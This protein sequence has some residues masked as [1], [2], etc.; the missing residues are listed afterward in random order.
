MVKTRKPLGS[1][2][3]L[4]NVSGEETLRNRVRPEQT[5]VQ[6][7]MNRMYERREEAWRGL[8]RER[9]VAF[10]RLFILCLVELENG[11]PL[12]TATYRLL[13]KTLCKR[14]IPWIH[15][16]LVY[17]MDE[18]WWPITL[19]QF[20]ELDGYLTEHLPL[21]QKDEPWD[22]IR[23]FFEE[24]LKRRAEYQRMEELEREAKEAY[25]RCMA[26]LNS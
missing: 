19:G 20:R 2:A 6:R 10:I 11:L 25:D 24:V 15:F 12:Q 22:A 5:P 8:T 3:G 16:R 21:V 4:M 26:N 18:R 1:L 17:T 13:K 7:H 23:Y 9:V 14:I